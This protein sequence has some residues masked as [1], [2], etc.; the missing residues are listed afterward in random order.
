MLHPLKLLLRNTVAL[1]PNEYRDVFIQLQNPD[2]PI[3]KIVNAYY[4]YYKRCQR[5]TYKEQLYD[6]LKDEL[7]LLKLRQRKL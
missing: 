5:L 7:L 3:T 1:K 6:E 2:L 4:I